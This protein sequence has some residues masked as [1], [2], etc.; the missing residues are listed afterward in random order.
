MCCGAL[1]RRS[2]IFSAYW[3]Y[4]TSVFSI[5]EK[6]INQRTILMFVTFEA[7]ISLAV[8]LVYFEH[9]AVA[10]LGM[11]GIIDAN[12][13]IM[14]L[15]FRCMCGIVGFHSA[16]ARRRRLSKAYMAMLAANIVST[17]IATY[18]LANCQCECWNLDTQELQCKILDSFDSAG[19]CGHRCVGEERA[20]FRFNVTDPGIAWTGPR[21]HCYQ[22]KDKKLRDESLYNK[23]WWHL[24]HLN[25]ERHNLPSDLSWLIRGKRPKQGTDDPLTQAE[26]SLRK[27]FEDN[28]CGGVEAR[29]DDNFDGRGRRF[30]LCR[31]DYP[32]KPL[33]HKR[34]EVS[35]S[36]GLAGALDCPP[37]TTRVLDRANCLVAA[38][39]YKKQFGGSDCDEA[40]TLGCYSDA[41]KVYYNTC[42]SRK[43]AFDHTPLCKSVPRDAPTDGESSDGINDKCP[44]LR[45]HHGVNNTVLCYDGTFEEIGTKCTKH[46]HGGR[47]QCPPDR[48]MMCAQRC[49]HGAFKEH[50]CET[51]CSNW[52]GRRACK[53]VEVRKL[54]SDDDY[55]EA[56]EYEEGYVPEDDVVKSSDK[57]D[58]EGLE[59]I[60]EEEAE[61]N[62]AD[63]VEGGDEVEGS[64]LWRRKKAMLT[65]QFSTLQATTVRWKIET[66]VSC[67]TCK[68]DFNRLL[69]G[70]GGVAFDECTRDTAQ[71]VC[72]ETCTHEEK[73]GG[74]KFEASTGHCRYHRSTKVCRLHTPDADCYT[75]VVDRNPFMEVFFLKNVAAELRMRASEETS[76]DEESL[77]CRVTFILSTFSLLLL[78]VVSLPILIVLSKF[79]DNRCGDT[80][81]MAQQFSIRFTEKHSD[82]RSSLDSVED[83]EDDF[84]VGAGGVVAPGNPTDSPRTNPPPASSWSLWRT[85]NGPAS[86]DNSAD[87]SRSAPGIELT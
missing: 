45:P 8:A 72:G 85:G 26:R 12:L 41:K 37:G 57:A 13:Y 73:C 70:K 11:L 78:N 53:E 16:C 76:E 48:P 82:R 27:C 30:R 66:N 79:I 75:K 46:K 36:M 83:D 34:H 80:F 39:R 68:E 31:Y 62:N 7:L 3:A 63:I 20:K 6:W 22:V 67:G 84:V 64:E 28:L 10:K 29:V 40:A 54:E 60:M 42:N 24:L 17:T 18:P 14:H 58:P 33:L 2:K 74:F 52:G 56:D 86:A 81:D 15:V 87:Q 49:G 59:D 32:L 9:N 50:C 69:I 23:L 47:K 65:F 61:D 4:L 38:T 43:M 77:W 21:K 19:S 51:D 5:P 71:K 25:E 55:K 1:R 44:W 35:Y